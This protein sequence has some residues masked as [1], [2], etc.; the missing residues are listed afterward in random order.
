MKC[1]RFSMVGKIQNTEYLKWQCGS[2]KDSRKGF[3]YHIQVSMF[4]I[5]KFLSIRRITVYKLLLVWDTIKLHILMIMVFLF[6]PSRTRITV[7]LTKY[8]SILICLES[9]PG[10]KEIF[11]GEIL[12]TEGK[13]NLVLL[14]NNPVKNQG[15]SFYLTSYI[16]LQLFQTIE[17]HT[18]SQLP[19]KSST[20]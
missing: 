6:L 19:M 7:I 3:T 14:F 5:E 13:I 20:V 16:K 2:I 11:E 12:V 9:N 15:K 18:E 17:N 1:I 10:A 8:R 4:N